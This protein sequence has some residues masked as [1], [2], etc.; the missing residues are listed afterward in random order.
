MAPGLVSISWESYPTAASNT[1]RN[2]YSDQDFTDVTIACEGEKQVKAHRVI[3]SA[4]SSFLHSILVENSNEHPVLCLTEVTFD[5][6]QRLIEFIYLG[7]VKI[8]E[9]EVTSFLDL[10]RELEVC[11]IIDQNQPVSTDRFGEMHTDESEDPLSDNVPQFSVDIKAEEEF[12][13]E[14]IKEES[15][16]NLEVPKVLKKEKLF[17]CNKCDFTSVHYASVR[18]HKISKHDGI[19]YHCDKCVKSFSDSSTLLRHKKS[20]HDGVVYR[21]ELCQKTFSD[22][23]ALTR[24]K[25]AKHSS[26]I[27]PV[28]DPFYEF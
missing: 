25:K 18:K 11:G 9:D 28:F 2:L 4:S 6:L 22:G 24:H 3:L 17:Q 26:E 23:S 8:P 7:E 5:L 10:G 14:N 19:K 21:C 16:D 15:I 20:I 12:L 27:P 13:I 1:V